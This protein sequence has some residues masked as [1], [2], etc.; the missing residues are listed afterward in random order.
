MMGLPMARNIT[1]AGMTVWAW[2]RSGDKAEPLTAAP[3][4]VA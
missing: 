2:N 3:E 1:R 4:Q